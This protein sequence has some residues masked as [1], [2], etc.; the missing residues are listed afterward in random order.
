MQQAEAK[1]YVIALA[2][3]PNSGKT[4]LYNALT[5]S[6]QYVGNWSGVTV[7]KKSGAVRQE[8]L[9]GGNEAE[10]VDL[11]G[12]YSLSP[13]SIEEKV[14]R[15][16]LTDGEPDVILNI[17]DA[18]N[19]ERNL[20]LTTQL[21]ELGLPVVVALNMADELKKKKITL[22]AAK[23]SAALGVPVVSVSAAYGSGITELS[24][25]LF[26]VCAM[27][28]KHRA[29]SFSVFGSADRELLREAEKTAKKYRPEHTGWYAEKLLVGDAGAMEELGS[30]SDEDKA[31]LAE[32]SRRFAPGGDGAS[33]AAYERYKAI[34]KI[35]EGAVTYDEHGLSVSDR[36]DSIITKRAVGIPLFLIIILLVFELTFGT[37]GSTLQSWT[38]WL[39]NSVFAGGA[40]KLLSAAGASD[41][42]ISLVVDGAIGGVGAVISFVPQIMLLFL[43]LSILED[44]GYM[45]RVAFTMD[46]FLRGIGLSGKAFIPMI[47]GFGC[48]VPAVMSART[49]EKE[50]DRKLTVMILPFISCSARAPVYGIFISAFFPRYRA[51]IMLALYLLGIC[52]SI[53]AAF[54]LKK[55]LF[56][57]KASPFVMEFPAYRLPSP[58]SLARSVWDKCRGFIVKAGTVILAASVIIWALGYFTPSFTAAQDASDSIIAAVG[59]FIAPVFAPMGFGI[60]QAAAALLAGISAKEA[61]VSTLG[62]LLGVS[63]ET[64]LAAALSGLFSPASALAFMVFVL[65][66]TPCVAAIA[67]MRRELGSA[68]R[69]LAAVGGQI[70]TAYI[71]SLITYLL[72]SLF[73]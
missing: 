38:S 49:L 1:K 6:R 63:G 42:V 30:I 5:G 9:R 31:Y 4:T 69:T 56:R 27:G 11:P 72:A 61:V 17:V 25:R 54:L 46:V 58:R 52:I 26:E 47:L 68:G 13:H 51:L 15:H 14:A 44:C 28:E 18:T 67:A 41:A 10:L 43:C 36:I 35:I 29:Q 64:G 53:G 62:V 34:G 71:F 33:R 48:T 39:I 19:L 32:L 7:E 66:Y 45:A 50:S 57:G 37:V 3:N 60:W 12:I 70:C 2:G 55:T 59:R 65:L 22:D 8:Y 40:E 20:F 24:D 16:Y 73:I 23:L 21:I